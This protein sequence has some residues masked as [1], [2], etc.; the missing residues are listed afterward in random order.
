MN[1]C[2]PI[3][4][5]QKVKEMAAYYLRRGQIRNYALFAMGVHTA[6]RVS[7]LLALRWKD[8][9]DFTRQRARESVT[10]TEGK[11]GKHKVVALNKT[12]AEAL[13]ELLGAARGPGG[14]GYVF[15][16][17]RDSGRAISRVQAYRIIRDGA[18]AVGLDGGISCHSLRKTF[19]YHSWRRGVSPAVIMDIYN[20]SSFRVTQRYL[21]I[22]Q[23]DKNRAYRGLTL[24]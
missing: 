20:H 6:L 22:T 7:D 21:G 5:R 23:E 16:S 14:N 15:E 4:D 9:Y 17:R 12:A 2:E 3:R 8:V 24:L 10:L 11:T 19:G 13:E 18:S 1:T